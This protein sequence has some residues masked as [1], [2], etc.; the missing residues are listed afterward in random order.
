MFDLIKTV[1]SL[2]GVLQRRRRA[3]G[4]LS[5]DA[6]SIMLPSEARQLVAAYAAAGFNSGGADVPSRQYLTDRMREIIGARGSEIELTLLEEK[7]MVPGYIISVSHGQKYGA[8]A[9]RIKV[10]IT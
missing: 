5:R 3:D 1:G 4:T 2:R 7:V 10:C 6:Q 8:R 9:A